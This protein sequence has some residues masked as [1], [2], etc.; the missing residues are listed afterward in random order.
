MLKMT[1]DFETRSECNLKQAGAWKYA[2]DPTTDVVCLAYKVNDD[3]AWIWYPEK[4]ARLFPGGHGLPLMTDQTVRRIVAKVIA[5]GYFEA[6]NAAFER[7]IWHNVM[8]KR[9]G[10][11]DLPVD[12][13]YCSAAKAS[14]HALPRSL[15]LAG[16]AMGLSVQKDDEGHRLMLKMC[17]PRKARK[18]EIKEVL[19]RG[20]DPDE[21][22]FWWEEPEDFIRLGQYCI[23]DVEAEHA[24]SSVLMPLPPTER[25]VYVADQKINQRGIP[26]DLDAIAGVI[27]S[28]KIHET[29]LKT[30]FEKLTPFTPTQVG[31]L[32][33][34]MDTRGVELPNLQKLTVAEA[35][36][37]TLPK[38]VRRVL[39]IRQSLG[40]S[41]TAKHLALQRMACADGRVRGTMMYHG[42]STGRWSG[43]GFQPHNLYRGDFGDYGPAIAYM[44]QRDLSAVEL[45]YGDPMGVAATLVRPMI[46]APPGF[47]LIA[48][49]L[50]AIEA[51][52]IAWLAR[53]EKLLD[54]FRGHGMIYEAAAV[55]VYGGT[56]WDITTEQR[57]VGKV[58]VL[59]C[60]YQ[61]HVGAFQAMASSYGVNISDEEA[62]KIVNKWR[63]NN[64][65]I[66]QLWYALEE[67]AINAIKNPQKATEYHG[68]K[69]KVH[70][71]FL[72]MRLPSGRFLYYCNP[73][74]RMREH[75]T[76]GQIKEG[77]TFWGM[78]SLTN[79]WQRTDTYGGKLAENA[80]QALCRDILAEGILCIEEKPKSPYRIIFHVHDEI[81]VEVP[82]G[83]GSV[84]EVERLMTQVPA[85]AAGL[86]IS[87][88]GWRGKRYHK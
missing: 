53:D 63:S 71:G 73:G 21:E 45:L 14:M 58:I 43:K 6:H 39:E 82:E 81:V 42:A 4:F 10:F 33:A 28:I 72:I 52:G 80:T 48:S 32:L 40:R 61:G 7:A 34:W 50:A 37:E 65:K 87:A 16:R 20:G 66:V 56:V 11:Q 29:K 38:D 62:E 3:R 1:I 27:E 54:I 31:K 30:E 76:T 74:T 55:D 86:P 84:E 59:A 78:N 24:L 57:R 36:E 19:E 12:K 64:Q 35:L 67:V 68:I 77:I 44:L 22:V 41:S 26:V 83:E 69:F 46:T 88:E 47:D 18:A 5:E 8:C 75:P 9:Y 49:D 85:W 60:G 25:R 51:R 79:Q 13:V 2:E 70:K 23:Q 15:D 17:K